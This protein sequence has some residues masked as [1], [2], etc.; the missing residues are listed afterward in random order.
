MM[1]PEYTGK[2][3][4]LSLTGASAKAECLFT[5]AKSSFYISLSRLGQGESLVRPLYTRETVFL[6]SLPP[7]SHRRDST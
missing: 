5:H 1:P 4:F 6:Y 2:R 3:P 7:T